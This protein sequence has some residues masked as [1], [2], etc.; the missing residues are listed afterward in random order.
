MT[1]AFLWRVYSVAAD[2]SP[3]VGKQKG[4]HL[5]HICGGRVQSSIQPEEHLQKQF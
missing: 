2:K 5:W 3:E 4:Q 1:C